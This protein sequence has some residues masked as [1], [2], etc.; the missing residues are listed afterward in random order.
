MNLSTRERG[1]LISA[2]AAMQANSAKVALLL[3]G[4]E[5]EQQQK[6]KRAA[7]RAVL[8]SHLALNLVKGVLYE[9][10]H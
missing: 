1:S 2:T 10:D 5:T 6:A 3:Q 7:D 4:A 8:A 9:L